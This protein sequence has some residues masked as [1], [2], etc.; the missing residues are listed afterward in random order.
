[1]SQFF[2]DRPVFA[3]V[4]AIVLM[5]AGCLAI[6]ELAVEQYPSIAAPTVQIT[7]TYPGASAKTVENSTTQVL[8]QK[9]TGIDK[10]RYF[11]SSS[12]DGLAQI[13]LTFE[14]E[15]DPD[16]A[17][18]QTQNKIQAA[19][20][21]LPAEVQQLGVHVTKSSG[22]FL[23]V[24]GF[25][26]E[27]DSISQAELGDLVASTVQDAVSR[28]TGVGNVTVFGEPHAMRLWLDPFKL[29]AKQLTPA[30]VYDA[31]R[32]Q[33]ADVSAGQL[34]ALPAVA[35]Q[36]INA[37]VIASTRLS[38]VEDF[39]K[40]LIKVHPDGTQT[41]LEDVARVE[42]G[43]QNYGSIVRYKRH[44]A[45]GFGVNLASG[46][47]AL[48]TAAAVKAR[49]AEL[50]A[51]LPPAVKVVYP[52][53]TTPF[54]RLSIGNV[55]V[56]LVEAMVLVVL[57]MLLFLQNWR[58]TLVPAIAVPVVLLGTFACLWALGLTI[59]VLTMFAIVLAIG[60]LV[61]DAIVVVENVERLM[62]EE[63]LSPKEAT[64]KSMTQIS[65]ALIGI[66]LVLS[67]VFVP[68]CFFGGAAGAIYKQFALTLISAMVLSV[69]VALILSPALCSTLLKPSHGSSKWFSLFNRSFDASRS[70]YA[71]SSAFLVRRR[72]WV[73]P[74]YAAL[75]AC[76]VFF[77][78]RLP[79]A[80]LPDEDQGIMFVLVNAPAGATAERTLASVKH[81]EDAILEGEKD[82]VANLFTVTGF[83]F[84]GIAQNAA[85]GFIGLKDWSERGHA[86]QSVFALSQRL[87]GRL[88]MEKDA[89]AFA[90]YPPPI[91]ELGTSSGFDAQLVDTAGLGHEALLG[92]R[93]QLLGMA[94]QSK[95][96]VGVR[97]NGLE[98]VP[99]FRVHVDQQKA[100]AMG[101]S[102]NDI[103][104]TLQAAWGSRYIND[105]IDRGRIKRVYMQADHPYRMLP[106]HLDYWS[107]R[108]LQGTM[109]PFSAFATASWDTGAT[110]LERFQG[111]S[112]FNIVGQAG[113]GVSTGQAMAELETLAKNLPQGVQLRWSGLSY[114]EQ[115]TGAGIWALYGLSI[116]VVFLC[117]AALY[118]SWIVPVAVLLSVPLGILGCCFLTWL[119]GMKSDIYFQVALL[120]TVGLVAKNAILIVEFAKRSFDEG[121]TKEEAAT[122]AASLRYRPIIM[123]S[124]AFMLGVL[125]LVLATGAGSA[126]QNAIGVGVLGGMIAATTLAIFF[127]PVAYVLVQRRRRDV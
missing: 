60:L 122:Q 125:P 40:I 66:S 35:G 11:S 12:S 87:M 23:L 69:L 108:T 89:M 72:F 68:M 36:Q 1:M 84:S 39:R 62:R 78:T 32:A 31:V 50:T 93:N 71:G 18:V 85:I 74:F 94:S 24:A 65:S 13:T 98:D 124:L 73:L 49:I 44:A 117:L 9:L 21:Q 20:A 5:L 91:L 51:V 82:N 48:D 96:L 70:A 63:G 43:S 121:A 97:P 120:T 127:V 102:I 27:D 33:N 37:T 92:A 61:D 2:I 118:E 54:V 79:T 81:I 67:A 119:F 7:A 4:L 112:S 88:F 25:Y 56:T 57:V 29:E 17:Q 64:R 111:L 101:A 104:Q 10:M 34:G 52:Y 26:T 95:L 3:W 14:P 123:T 19:L 45:V 22:S 75:L 126:S 76:M 58:V 16:I 46:A 90:I 113:P 114:E 109:L 55:L 15:A 116:L 28:V 105:F 42:L 115:K 41:L 47:N 80:F 110:K 106:E 6:R 53:D 30:D 59:N 100:A 107:V 86:N 83:S 8:E 99:Q 38:T 103:N 77:F